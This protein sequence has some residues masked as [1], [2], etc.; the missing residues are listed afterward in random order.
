M[1]MYIVEFGLAYESSIVVRIF[2]EE[3]LA[4]TWLLANWKN[5]QQFDFDYARIIERTTNDYNPYN[6]DEFEL[7]NETIM[8]IRGN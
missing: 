5:S 8:E 2:E 4:K 6:Q 7:L 1:K 3:G